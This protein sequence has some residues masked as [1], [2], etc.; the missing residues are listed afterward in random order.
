MTPDQLIAHR[1][2]RQRYPENT[3][4]AIEQAL[5]AGAK[6]IEIDI[7]FSADKVPVLCHD[8]NLLRLSGESIDIHQCTLKSLG[9]YSAYEPDR[10]GDSFKGNPF[11]TL[12][13]CLELIASHPET[14]LYIEI[15][16]S[17]IRHF[18]HDTVL[19]NL[20]AT[21]RSQQHQCVFIS[22][23]FKI[24]DMAVAAGWQR[25]GPVLEQWSQLDKLKKNNA[26]IE[27]VFCDYQIV[28]ENFNPAAAPYPLA[29]YEVADIKLANDLIQRGISLIETFSIGELLAHS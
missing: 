6:R 5:I 7:Q 8:R 3:L 25:T 15:K 24:L 14:T 4:I 12:A 20:L 27:I 28:P 29:T 9:N 18:G 19:N 23:D 26:A 2:W 22:F 16:R 11:S 10:L 13:E 21:C 1:G 17:S